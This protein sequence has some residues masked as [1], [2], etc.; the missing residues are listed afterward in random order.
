M[1]I[2]A[3][4][5]ANALDA[6]ITRLNDN[7]LNLDSL[8][9]SPGVADELDAILLRLRNLRSIVSEKADSI[10]SAAAR[11]RRKL[12]TEPYYASH[13]RQPT[14]VGLWILAPLDRQGV[15][16]LS[17]TEEWRGDIGELLADD[18]PITAILGIDGIPPDTRWA[19]LP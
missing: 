11:R 18:R 2:I 7:G 16:D 4:R 9:V 19:V 14:D 12:Y 5:L 17:N 10:E 3:R 6:A 15:P 8:A 13:G 1:S